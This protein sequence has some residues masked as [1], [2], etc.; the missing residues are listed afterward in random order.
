MVPA[1]NER[2]D[3]RLEDRLHSLLDPLER[4][5]DESGHRI[6]VTVIDDVED[7]ERVDFREQVVGTNET[8][9]VPDRRGTFA[10][11]RPKAGRV[12]PRNPEEHAFRRPKVLRLGKA[13]EGGDLGEPG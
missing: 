11:A 3:P 2:D 7:A 10:G 9:M 1:G 8:G 5:F 4:L 13:G 12:V 6:D